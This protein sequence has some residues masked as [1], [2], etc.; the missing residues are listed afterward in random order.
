MK[1]VAKFLSALGMFI[2]IL[3]SGHVAFAEEQLQKPIVVFYS[4]HQD[5]ELLTMGHAITM[6]VEEGY[7]VHVVLLTDGKSSASVH[8]V[9][10]EMEKKYLQPLSS[11][12]FSYARN[13][14]FVRSLTSL[15]VKRRNIH[16]SGLKDGSTT[17]NQVENIVLKYKTRFPD[18]EHMAFSYHDDHIDH[19]NSGAALQNLYKNNIIKQPKYYIQNRERATVNGAFEPYLAIY[20]QRIESA[21]APYLDWNPLRRMYS[22]GQ[23][24]VPYDFQLLKQDPR[25]KFHK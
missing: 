1:Q 11:E 4:P 9:N 19:R 8:S 17:L 18:A 12:E 21:M 14:E 25:S 3:I 15:G 5:D 22:I 16:M 23:I 24:S 13:L 10:K 7:E 6:Y 20:D 2:I